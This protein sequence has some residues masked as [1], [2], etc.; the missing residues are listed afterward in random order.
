MEKEVASD[1]MLILCKKCGTKNRVD[2]SIKDKTIRCGKCGNPLTLDLADNIRPTLDK[3]R[4][5]AGEVKMQFEDYTRYKVCSI[6]V[7][8]VEDTLHVKWKVETD[9]EE[10]WRLKQRWSIEYY[11]TIK[12]L[13]ALYKNAPDLLQTF[14]ISFFERY[15]NFA[16]EDEEDN[17]RDLCLLSIRITRKKVRELEEKF[18]SEDILSIKGPKRQS[19][20]DELQR[21][22]RDLTSVRQN[23][24]GTLINKSSLIYK[25]VKPF[26]LT[27]E[28]EEPVKEIYIREEKDKLE[29]KKLTAM[30]L[31]ENNIERLN[32][33]DT[34]YIRIFARKYGLGNE[35]RRKNLKD[36]L[37]SKDIKLP[38]KV[39]YRLIRKELDEISYEMFHKKI[40]VPEK[41]SLNHFIRRYLELIPEPEEQIHN[42]YRFLIEKNIIIED[43]SM[44]VERLKQ[45]VNKVQKSIEVEQF[46]RK[47]VGD[48][49]TDKAREEMP[50]LDGIKI[51]SLVDPNS[52]SYQF[53][54]QTVLSGKTGGIGSVM[55]LYADNF[56]DTKNNRAMLLFFLKD[57]S[58]ISDPS[59]V[60]IDEE[61]KKIQYEDIPEPLEEEVETFDSYSSKEILDNLSDFDF[62][63]SL[64]LMRYLFERM[65]FNA[66]VVEKDEG[67]T[68]VIFLDNQ[69]DEKLVVNFFYHDGYLDVESMYQ[70]TD[71]VK[72]Y[73][74]DYGI[75]VCTGFFSKEAIQYALE[76][77][78]ELIDQNKIKRLVA[79]VF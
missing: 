71:L 73:H 19:S 57:E 30:K 18:S 17:F 5:V 45:I 60:K 22:T 79:N 26:D 33:L 66:S 28:A 53:F 52:E 47:L 12:M 20:M 44:N 46:E 69:E 42:F 27:G 78:V 4:S 75:G 38:E 68:G 77:D 11:Y 39:I 41:L 58:L 61:I 63:K 7:D 2:S 24:R 74:A 29:D 54:K 72:T 37:D 31:I 76:S 40:K 35:E 43:V 56:M 64:H 51:E 65:G 50:E 6:S 32:Q 9:I 8:L 62:N 23:Y 70:I 1:K 14:A 34:S 16:P 13:I 67:K 21:F 25:A 55:R 48:V 36:L 59:D 3:L 10:L 15:M 49:G